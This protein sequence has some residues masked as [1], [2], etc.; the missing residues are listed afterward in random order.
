MRNVLLV[1]DEPLIVKGMQSIIDWNANHMQIADTARNGVEALAK[2]D[3]LSVDLVI[4]DIMMPQMTGL[5]LIR[6]VK[7]RSPLTKFIILSGYEE[8]NYVREGITLGVENYLLKPVNIGELE[9]TI[10]HMQHDWER[11]EIRQIQM[12]Q[13][14]RI[15]RTNILQRWANET[16]DAKEF[17]ERA[18]LLEL[19]LTKSSY[20]AAALRI[21]TDLDHGMDD[22]QFYRPVIA[23]QCEI[24]GR[25]HV[26]DGCEIICF[27]DQ[28]GDIIVLFAST[29]RE[30]EEWQVQSLC[31]MKQWISSDTGASV[32]GVKGLSEQSYLGVPQ[33]SKQVKLWLQNHLL[34]ES[35]TI[36]V[37]SDNGS[38]AGQ[39][40]EKRE[41]VMDQ[42]HKLLRDGKS[43]EVDRFIDDF[44]AVPSED[45]HPARTPFF[46][47]A[48]QL[49]LAAKNLEKTP[50]YGGVFGPLSRIHTLSGLK[51]LV[52]RVV[53]QT[54]DTYHA[55]ERDYSPHVMA[56]LDFV[57][58]TYKEELSLKTLSQ[59]LDLHPNYLGQ[60]FQQEAG[61]SFSDYV[62]QYRIERATHLLLYSD[63]K[64][65]EVA[66]EVG[67][68]DTSYFYRQFKKYAG[69]SPTEL[70]SMYMK[71]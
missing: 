3:G 67:F 21:V 18:Q 6:E 58:N 34:G 61:T 63:K 62:N 48:I 4:T 10:K 28:E 11:E 31:G 14:W 51:R 17:R 49:M 19:P 71:K 47:S 9:A 52:K 60:L 5:E 37:T 39:A 15:L 1:D 27:P 29:G 33:S 56:A 24:I 45:G 44:F 38:E 35:E 54:L 2:L 59:K 40:C 55:T 22:P 66:A 65:A 68:W 46:N 25:T 36:I 64:T 13:S 57:K 70:R 26:P 8:F 30:G 42:F 23:E 53:H 41:P 32:W 43:L 50:D 12:D 20:C 7:V 69:V 16:I